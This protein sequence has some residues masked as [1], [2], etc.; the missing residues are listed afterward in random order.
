MAAR[1]LVSPF[2]QSLSCL[3]WNL[4][5]MDDELPPS[6]SEISGRVV[7]RD[8]SVPVDMRSISS[9]DD[10]D[11]RMTFSNSDPF[12]EFNMDLDTDYFS[13]DSPLSEDEKHASSLP[14]DRRFEATRQNL[15]AS[16]RRSQATRRSLTITTPHV[17]EYGRRG[18]VKGVIESVEDSSQKLQKCFIVAN[19]VP[20][21]KTT[22]AQKA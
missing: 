11:W 12:D 15:E 1:L 6:I 13:L 2:E 8:W 21:G 20:N 5:G 22:H 7:L 19:M 4:E 3:D 16:M 17:E 18:S 14:F 9:I 10:E